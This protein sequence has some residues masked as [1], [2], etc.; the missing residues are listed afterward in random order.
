MRHPFNARVLREG[1]LPPVLRPTSSAEGFDTSARN[2]FLP[3]AQPFDKLRANGLES[4]EEILL[5]EIA[6]CAL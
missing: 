4:A 1:A 2:G 5:I 6:L 3:A